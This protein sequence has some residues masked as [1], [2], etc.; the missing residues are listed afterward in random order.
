MSYCEV[1]TSVGQA[2]TFGETMELDPLHRRLEH[3]VQPAPS[4][5]LLSAAKLQAAKDDHWLSDR[6]WIDDRLPSVQL[7]SSAPD[8]IK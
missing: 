3:S 4:L 1:S 8:R 2:I 7:V 6:E 5:V